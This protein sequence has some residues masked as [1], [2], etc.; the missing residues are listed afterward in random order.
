MVEK[1]AAAGVEIVSSNYFECAEHD[2]KT[3]SLDAHLK[4]LREEP[5]IMQFGSYPCQRCGKTVTVVP[6][7]IDAPA[8]DSGLPKDN[9]KQ[10]H[11]DFNMVSKRPGLNTVRGGLG[12]C[13]DCKKAVLKELQ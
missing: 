13:E 3:K 11:K 7:Y 12:T 4:H 2:H 8:P 10:V 1:K 6:D 5:H 9:T